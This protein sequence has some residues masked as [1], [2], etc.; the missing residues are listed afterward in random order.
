MSYILI[1]DDEIEICRMMQNFLAPRGYKVVYAVTGRGGI[2]AFIDVKPQIVLLDICLTDISGLEVLK[3]IKSITP[4]TVVIIITGSAVE[5]DRIKAM[6]FG[7]D[8]YICKPFSIGKVHRL[9]TKIGK[10][11]QARLGRELRQD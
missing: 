5:D 3:I 7:A 10:S 11:Y 1:I 4:S 8:F 9:L 6:E 2:D